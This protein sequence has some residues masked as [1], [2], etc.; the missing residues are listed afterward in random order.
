MKYQLSETRKEE[1]LIE[2]TLSSQIP[3][4]AA[5]V[6]HHRGSP[7]TSGL[8]VTCLEVIPPEGQRQ[9]DLYTN[10]CQSLI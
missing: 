7:G 5:G 10:S 8:K 2:D 4:W 3:L 6:C 1:Q 9:R